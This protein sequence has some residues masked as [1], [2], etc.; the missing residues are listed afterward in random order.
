MSCR[1]SVRVVPDLVLLAI[2]PERLGTKTPTK[3]A[4]S[5]GELPTAIVFTTVLNVGLAGFV[6]MTETLL[7]LFFAT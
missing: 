2:A 6:S 5:R 3:L 4:T 7:D 1:F